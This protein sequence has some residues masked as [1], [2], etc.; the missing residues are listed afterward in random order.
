MTTD[1]NTLGPAEHIIQAIL[2]HSDHM[3][4]NRP[5][6]IVA[7]ARQSTGVRWEPVTQ[8]LEGDTK[9]VYKLVKQGRKS[10]R[11]KLGNLL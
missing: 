2:T 4:H 6:I 10:V 3:V 5:G 1:A 9:V 8:R 7:D 11:I